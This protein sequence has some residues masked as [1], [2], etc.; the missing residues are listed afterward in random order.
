VRAVVCDRYGPPE[1]QRIAEVERPVPRAD[2]VLVKIHATTVT[3]TDCGIRAGKPFL[4]R[5]FFGLRR[6]KQPILAPSWRER[7]QASA[8]R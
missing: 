1:V 4:V 7:S 8:R 5:F 2:E 3:R 6:P